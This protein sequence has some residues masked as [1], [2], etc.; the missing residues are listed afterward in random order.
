MAVSQSRARPICLVVALGALVGIAMLSSPERPSAALT[1]GSTQELTASS[2][3]VTDKAG[4]VRVVLSAGS[5]TFLSPEGAE[6][7]SLGPVATTPLG[8]AGLRIMGEEGKARLLVG[9][10][11]GGEPHVTL[12]SEKGIPR[13]QCGLFEGQSFLHLL[14]DVGETRVELTVRQEGSTMRL[15]DEDGKRV[16]AVP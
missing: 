3:A 11:A 1:D 10:G 4:R 13:V 14:D 16:W 5:L 8:G 9:L 7:I 6:A 15:R 2:V 12:L